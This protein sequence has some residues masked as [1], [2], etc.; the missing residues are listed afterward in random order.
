MPT[1]VSLSYSSSGVRDA[2]LIV[3]EP[4]D[5]LAV[6]HHRRVLLVDDDVVSLQVWALLLADAGVEV[7][8]APGAEACLRAVG[9]RDFDLIVIDLRLEGDSG[10]DVMRRLRDRGVLV[11]FILATG[12]ASVAVTVQAMRLGARTVLE[13]PL[14]G[15][16]FLVPVLREL[17]AAGLAAVT[18][19]HAVQST[20]QRWALYVLRATDVVSD[21]RTLADWARAAGVSRSALIESCARLDIP[22]RDGRDLAR[23]LRLVRRVSESWD[24]EAALDVAD[25]RTFRNLLVRAGL[26]DPPHG[27]RPAPQQFLAMQRFVPQTNAGLAALRQMVGN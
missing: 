7:Q 9:E 14:V 13:K 5:L 11:P 8:V 18:D 27:S 23:V 12:H 1:S 21:P 19:L 25:R 2:A 22:P 26:A 20:A 16:D 17:Q 6:P 10:L 4:A 15:E 24:P 3:C